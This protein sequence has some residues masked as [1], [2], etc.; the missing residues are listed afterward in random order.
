VDAKMRSDLLQRGPVVESRLYQ[1][2]P[3]TVA[4]WGVDRSVLMRSRLPI[5]VH[6]G[7]RLALLDTRAWCCGMRWFLRRLL[8][9]L[10]VVVQPVAKAFLPK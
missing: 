3:A 7:F 2:A 1:A 10:L 5:T 9:A 8:A 6:G 4:G